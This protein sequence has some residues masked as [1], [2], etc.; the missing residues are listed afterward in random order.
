[1]NDFEQIPA[2]IRAGPVK[3]GWGRVGQGRSRGL[4]WNED[5]RAHPTL[6]A[7]GLETGWVSTPGRETDK[8]NDLAF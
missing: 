5:F 7:Q 4:S 1:M 8:G 2:L 6:T 3:W